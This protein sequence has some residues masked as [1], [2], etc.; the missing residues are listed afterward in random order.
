MALPIKV[1]FNPVRNFESM[2]SKRHGFQLD[3]I[4]ISL[5]WIFVSQPVEKIQAQTSLFASLPPET[6]PIEISFK[7]TNN[8]AFA[9]DTVLLLPFQLEVARLPESGP[10]TPLDRRKQ[11]LALNIRN[12]KERLPLRFVGM[13]DSGHERWELPYFQSELWFMQKDDAVT[14]FWKRVDRNQSYPLTLILNRHSR[15]PVD[16]DNKSNL[17]P[18][19]ARY[20]LKMIHPIDSTDVQEAVAI[21][22]KTSD[23]QIHGTFLTESG[24]YRYLSGVRTGNRLQLS[25]F[26][27]VFAY[28]VDLQLSEDGFE[29]WIHYGASFSHRLVAEA[30]EKAALK[31]PEHL[32][33][34]T[35]ESGTL[36][37]ELPYYHEPRWFK[38]TPGKVT[39]VQIMGSWCPNCLDETRLFNYFHQQYADQGLQLVAISFE[40]SQ[41]KEKA[42]PMIDKFVRDLVIPY[43]VLFGGKASQD[44]VQKVLP[45]LTGFQAYPTTLFVDKK[46][47]VRKV[48]TGFS[49][50]ATPHYDQYVLKT[51]QFIEQLLQE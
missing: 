4:L 37:L 24:D 33:Q 41:E 16:S 28:L 38:F 5:L 22:K 7:P 48:H 20:Q 44:Q 32:T 11:N 40:R 51:S 36:S 29:G 27:G 47:V 9:S 34:F 42:F 46:G 50:P 1:G 39:I 18:L 43:P 13:S 17:I 3:R 23:G 35:A 8:P 49:G 19:A 10:P 31:N 14:G 15:F 26:N 25:T 30:N 12:G 6:Y 45:G 2:K 21:L